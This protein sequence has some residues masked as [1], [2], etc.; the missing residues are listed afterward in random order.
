MTQAD[1]IQIEGQNLSHQRGKMLQTGSEKGQIK[2]AQTLDN[3]SGNISSQGTLS[4]DVNTLA[5]QQGVV[6]AAKVGSLILNAK[7]SVDNTQGT[8]FA[9]QDFT[10]NTQS[11]TNI[12]GKAISKQGNMLLATEDL[13]GQRGE[14]IAQGDLSLSGKG[15]DLTA[16]NTQAQHIQLRANNLTHQQGTM[17]QLGEREGTIEVSQ[18]INNS[19]GDIS[20]NGSWLIKANTL[21]NQQGK[22]FS[23]RMGKLDLQIQQVLDNTGGA[24]TGRQGVFVE[25]QSLINRTGKVIA[26]MG[27]ITLNS[28][29][30][31]GD[32]GEILAAH[33]LNIESGTLSLNQ[34]VTKRITS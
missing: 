3:Q 18:Q 32:E 30:I 28:Q 23:A 16:A 33:A 6:V 19:A 12:D 4:L 13:Q 10:L 11:F 26:S 15:I 29:S 34:A 22:I 21:D 25:T 5:N 2:L 27:N 17:T 31:E 7:Q 24:L 1:N 20:G 8:L 14:I 9:E